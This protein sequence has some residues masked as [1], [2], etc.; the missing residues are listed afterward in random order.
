MKKNALIAAGVWVAAT[1]LNLA[2]LPSRHMVRVKAEAVSHAPMPLIVRAPGVLQPKDAATLKA[3]FDGPILQ[4]LYKEGDK[5][6]A[7]QM[8][9]EIGRAVIQPQYLGRYNEVKNAESELV[10]ARKEVKLQKALY[11]KSAVPMSAVEDANRSLERAIQ[12]LEM[13][14]ASFKPETERWNKNLMYAP[15]A[16]TVIRDTLGA[17][18][19]VSAGKEI[20]SL[21]DLSSYTMQAQIDELDIGSVKSGQTAVI[22]LQAYEQQPLQATVVKV[23]SQADDK[24]ATHYQVQLKIDSI[25]SL[26]VL[27]QFTG[28]GKIVVGETPPVISVP[29]SAVAARSGKRFVWVVS[30]LRKISERPIEIGRSNPDRVEITSGLSDGDRVCAPADPAWRDG[31]RVIIDE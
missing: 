4:K 27:P 22:R 21:G 24:G 29:L 20:V 19:N 30:V 10:K 2:L 16:G 14:S 17:E 1:A 15:F 31:M 5:V 7:G 18:K 6:K 13:S 25:G 12:T 11:K 8:L 26:P 23:G 3:E 9:I 28:E